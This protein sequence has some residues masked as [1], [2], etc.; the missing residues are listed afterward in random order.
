MKV[1]RID[2]DEDKP[3]CR[4][5]LTRQE[6]RELKAYLGKMEVSNDTID[7]DQILFNKLSK[8]LKGD[9]CN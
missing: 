6:A 2:Q 4:I 1:E 5:E 7:I 8:L 3:F 9:S